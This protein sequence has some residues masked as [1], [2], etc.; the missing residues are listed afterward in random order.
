MNAFPFGD[1][2]S[3]RVKEQVYLPDWTSP[4]RLAYTL[5]SSRI[6]AE[7]LTEGTEGSVS[8]VPLGFKSLC[9]EQD[10]QERCL[11]P[12][13]D[14]AVSLDQ[15]HD[16]TG[17]VVR[18]AIEPEPL[19]VLETTDE[20]LVFF[21]KLRR[22]AESRGLEEVSQAHLGVCYDICHQAVEHEEIADSI[23]A[24][25][26]AEI[27]IN[28][29]HITCAV[30]LRNPS[31]NLEGRRF[32]AQ[33]AEPRYLHQT[34]CRLNGEN[35]SQTDLTAEFAL[36]P[37]DEWLQAERWRI[38]FHVPVHAESLGPLGTTRVELLQGLEAVRDLEYAPHLEVE[39]YTWNVLPGETQPD[40]L[41]GMSLEL[42]SAAQVIDS[43][44][45][46]R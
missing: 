34:F 13:L 7:L 30:E 36:N 43:L 23:S 28:K 20:T 2:H 41:K 3:E 19:C 37:P 17:R 38:H 11:D 32:L 35:V 33:F 45:E 9:L 8:T 5:R 16:D 18:L 44:R 12:L 25:K 4:E 21:E 10:F 1:F 29:V 39:T 42:Q 40:I 46:N 6:L 26:Q 27:R 24:L 31:E 22:R 14:L 15:L